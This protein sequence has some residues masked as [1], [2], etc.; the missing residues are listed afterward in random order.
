ML[1]GIDK[2]L[3]FPF[4]KGFKGSRCATEM[5]VRHKYNRTITLLLPFPRLSPLPSRIGQPTLISTYKVR[6]LL[7]LLLLHPGLRHL[8]YTPSQINVPYGYEIEPTPTV[9]SRNSFCYG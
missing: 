7:I 3:E 9:H 1:Q 4:G 8:G 2:G 6:Y 5:G